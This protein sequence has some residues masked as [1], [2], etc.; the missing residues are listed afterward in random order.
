M[1]MGVYV[2][3]AACMAKVEAPPVAVTGTFDPK[4]RPEFFSEVE[5]SIRWTMEFADGATARC[6]ATYDEQVS[7]FR[8]EGPRGWAE[9]GDPAF[10]YD[11]PRLTTSNGRVRLPAVNHQVAQLDGIMEC[12]LTG[13]PSPVPGEMG[14]RDM[15]VVEAIYASAKAG[16]KRVEVMA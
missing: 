14:R 15:T 3:Q 6:H 16:G 10:Y 9:F 12:L 7:T 2:I 5:E 11:T 8:A 1:D 4:Q 13:R